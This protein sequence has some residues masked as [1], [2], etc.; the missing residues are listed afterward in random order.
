MAFNTPK[1]KIDRSFGIE[2][3]LNKADGSFDTSF[4]SPWKNA[5]FKGLHFNCYIF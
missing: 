3:N 2:L 1:S 5:D 4:N